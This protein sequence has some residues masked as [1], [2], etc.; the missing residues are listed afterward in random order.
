MIYRVKPVSNL[1]IVMPDGFSAG[2]DRWNLI[3][4]LRKHRIIIETIYTVRTLAPPRLEL[5]VGLLPSGVEFLLS[6]P[7]SALLQ[8]GDR[9]WMGLSVSDLDVCKFLNLFSF[10]HDYFLKAKRPLPIWCGVYVRLPIVKIRNF[11]RESKTSSESSSSLVSDSACWERSSPSEQAD[12][13]SD[14]TGNSG[15]FFSLLSL[16]SSSQTASARIG[17][18][19]IYN[20]IS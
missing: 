12:G 6:Q 2:K 8:C 1:L 17:L 11:S 9:M 10:V 16:S 4:S 5:V 20:K 18:F 13:D 7:N 15:Q 19:N 14:F 3:F